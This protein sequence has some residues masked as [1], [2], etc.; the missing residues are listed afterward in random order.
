MGLHAPQSKN[1]SPSQ[2]SGA[3]KNDSHKNR[4]IKLPARVDMK[5]SDFL[6]DTLVVNM[7]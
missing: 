6:F 5:S 1:N 2:L 3:A 7:C 4:F